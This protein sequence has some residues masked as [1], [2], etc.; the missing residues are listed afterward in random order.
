MFSLRNGILSIAAGLCLFSIGLTRS[1]AQ[2]P[3]PAPTPPG[4]VFFHEFFGNM[5]Y[6]DPEAKTQL[7]QGTANGFTFT[8]P[9]VGGIAKLVQ[10]F[11]AQVMLRLP[12]ASSPAGMSDS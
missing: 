9:V 7:A 5:A 2:A 10:P 12:D 6:T 11:G 8:P 4:F 3:A 1:R